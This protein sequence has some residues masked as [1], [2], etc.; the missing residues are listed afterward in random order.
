MQS[1]SIKKIITFLAVTLALSS[2]FYYLILTGG[3]LDTAG[4]LYVLGLMWAPGLAGI[5]TQLVFERSLRGMGWKLGKFKY[6]A[7]A[8]LLPLAYCLVVYGI[9]WATGLSGFP[10]PA[11]MPLIRER[12]GGLTA[13]PAL[14]ILLTM[15]LT[16]IFGLIP[17]LIS[18]LGEEIGWRGLFVPE[19]AKVTGFG[20]VALI[21]GGVWAAW[22]M[23]LLLFSDYNLPGAPVWYAAL[24]FTVL[25]IGISYAFAWLRLK[26]GSLWT[27]VL[28][29]TMHNIFV[30]GVFTP[31]T[32]RNELTPYIIDEFGIGL[33][34]AGL[35][36][37]FYYWRKRKALPQ[38]QE[39]EAEGLLARAM[40]QI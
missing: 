8:F 29:H 19:L 11:L 27:A 31:F 15:A 9:T 21:S 16:V 40:G 39:K 18:S 33:A 4:G 34:L 23:P 10:E 30:Q 12:W 20:R 26:S 28:L 3:S 7:A 32:E 25:V 36:V 14:Q 5:I 37:A 2:I 17:G 1:K 22:H 35:V 38:E 13:S 24:M 6:L